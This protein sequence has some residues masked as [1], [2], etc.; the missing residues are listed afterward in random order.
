M[1]S[2]AEFHH[3]FVFAIVQGQWLQIILFFFLLEISV[4]HCFW[5]LWDLTW[6][7]SAVVPDLVKVVVGQPVG[8]LCAAWTVE[9]QEFFA[10]GWVYYTGVH[11]HFCFPAHAL[12]LSSSSLWVNVN[13]GAWSWCVR[14]CLQK[15]SRNQKKK[16]LEMKHWTRLSV[17]V[18]RFSMLGLYLWMY[19]C[20]RTAQDVL[21]CIL[22]MPTVLL[23]KYLEGYR[24]KSKHVFSYAWSES[25][26][27]LSINQERMGLT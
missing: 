24:S 26:L 27:A 14:C 18:L 19:C 9:V 5:K 22:S 25:S 23:Q 12:F 4:A 11:A 3:L 2:D 20:L 13:A 1:Y 21:I 17:V 7:F 15:I 10:D 8:F 6:M 16:S